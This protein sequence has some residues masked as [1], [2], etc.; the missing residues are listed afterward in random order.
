MGLR[1]TPFAFTEHGILMLSS[2]L[3]SDRVEKVN[4]L[5]I[6][7][8]V[9]LREILFVHKDMEHQLEKVQTKL[10]EHNNQIRIIFECLKQL[11]QSKQEE[12]IL[13]NEKELDLN[14]RIDRIIF[15]F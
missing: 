2:V 6:D 14:Q 7:T 4:I 8:F 11:E 15:R 13:K 5:I 12:T 3:N 1:V 10:D 9:R